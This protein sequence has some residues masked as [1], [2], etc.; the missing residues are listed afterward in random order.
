MVCLGIFTG[1]DPLLLEPGLVVVFWL[2]QCVG[3]TLD[4]D[5]SNSKVCSALI[6]SMYVDILETSGALLCMTKF[7]GLR[8]PAT[9]DPENSTTTYCVAA[10]SISQGTLMRTSPV[11]AFA[12]S[13]TVIS[14]RGQSGTI[15]MF[16][17]TVSS[18][19]FIPFFAS[20]PPSLGRPVVLSL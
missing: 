11:T 1:C 14:E 20:I 2:L 3:N 6:T 15:V 5:H 19:L 9:S 8:D 13:A 18:I 16:A 12:E 17:D 4:Y 7:T 10:F